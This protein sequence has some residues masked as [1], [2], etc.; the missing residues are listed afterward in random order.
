MP[1][2]MIPALRAANLS[3]RSGAIRPVCARAR[4]STGLISTAATVVSM[5]RDRNESPEDRAARK[6]LVKEEKAARRARREGDVPDDYGQKN[7]ELCHKMKDLLIRSATPP[8]LFTASS[9]NFYLLSFS[10]SRA[11]NKRHTLRTQITL[12]FACV[13]RVH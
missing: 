3:L 1:F 7:C 13:V 9:R 12:A 8:S 10:G 11:I 2:A 6:A 4:N 5:A